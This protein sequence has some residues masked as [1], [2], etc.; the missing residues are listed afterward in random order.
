MSLRQLGHEAAGG[1]LATATIAPMKIHLRLSLMVVLSVGSSG[2]TLN[3]SSNSSASTSL[4]QPPLLPSW[5]HRVF[6][7]CNY[8]QFLSSTVPPFFLGQADLT[9]RDPPA[10]ASQVLG[11]KPCA[12]TAPRQ[13]GVV[14]ERGRG[15]CVTE[16]QWRTGDKVRSQFSLLHCGF[17]GCSSDV[18]AS[19]LNH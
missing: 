6:F 8:K 18:T 13:F 12:T 16:H 17:Q 14:V 19:T 1:T 15:A 3:I 2:S 5:S 9:R 4:T 11:L 7:L 10:S